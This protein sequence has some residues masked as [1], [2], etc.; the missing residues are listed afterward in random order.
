MKINLAWDPHARLPF[1]V[2]P[3]N[4]FFFLERQNSWT[5]LHRL[6]HIASNPSLPA[7]I[8]KVSLEANREVPPKQPDLDDPPQFHTNLEVQ[9]KKYRHS[10]RSRPRGPRKG[11]IFWGS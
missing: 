4:D 8:V 5:R 7:A 10:S 3:N 11:T 1:P 2:S 9:T 6:H